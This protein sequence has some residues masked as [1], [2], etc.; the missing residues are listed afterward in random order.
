MW[1]LEKWYRCTYLQ[2]RD[3]D[4][5]VRNRCMDAKGKRGRIDCEIGIDSYTPLCRQLITNENRLRSTGNSYSVF[6]GDINGKEIQGRGGDLLCCTAET[7]I[8]L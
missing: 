4:R 8:T 2:S 6:C 3:S 7:N 1:N 5:D